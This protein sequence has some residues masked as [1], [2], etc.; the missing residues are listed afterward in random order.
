MS[1]REQLFEVLTHQVNQLQED[2]DNARHTDNG[3]KALTCTDARLRFG[4]AQ[5]TGE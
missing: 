5:V 4:V 3:G 1:R 2:V